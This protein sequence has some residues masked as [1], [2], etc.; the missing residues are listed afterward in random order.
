MLGKMPIGDQCLQMVFD[1][2]AIGTSNSHSLADR[3]TSVLLGY[4]KK[5]QGQFRQ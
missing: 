5:L 1:G 2:V 3:Y 4:F